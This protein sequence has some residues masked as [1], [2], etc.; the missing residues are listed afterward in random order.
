MGRVRTINRFMWI[1]IALAMLV[2]S[3]MSEA[4][5]LTD[6]CQHIFRK[7]AD[8][9]HYRIDSLYEG[10]L[11]IKILAQVKKLEFITVPLSAL[12]PIHPISFSH[13]QKKVQERAGALKAYVAGSGLPDRWSFD[14]LDKII[15]SKNGIRVLRDVDGKYVVFDGNGRVEALRNAFP[16]RDDE[17]VE[18]Q[19]FEMPGGSITDL[20]H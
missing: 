9:P 11:R 19:Y 3:P 7:M 13:T 10:W 6:R 1:W 8:V 17:E 18:V 15:P 12:K 2:A 20:V 4:G 5:G 16:N 14:L